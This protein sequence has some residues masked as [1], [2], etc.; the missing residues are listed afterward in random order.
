[1][2]SPIEASVQ[3]L[4]G[5]VLTPNGMSKDGVVAIQGERIAYAAMPP[6]CPQ[7]L[8]SPH[9]RLSISRMAILFPALSISMYMA[10]TA[11]I[12]WMRPRKT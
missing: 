11:R 6:T 8:K 5:H 10:G 1:M 7:H 3:L 12:S 4:Y 9:W 2:S